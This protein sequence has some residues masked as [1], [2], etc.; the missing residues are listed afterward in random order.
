MR[1]MIPDNAPK[2]LLDFIITKLSFKDYLESKHPE[3]HENRWAN[4]EELLS[5]AT[6]LAETKIYVN[7]PPGRAGGGHTFS[8]RVDPDTLERQDTPE[9]V[10]SWNRTWAFLEW[11]LRPYEDR[12]KAGTK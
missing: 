2:D 7:P 9:Q 6:D 5:Q 1:T 10:D 3:D 4:V 11:H 12:S 8:R